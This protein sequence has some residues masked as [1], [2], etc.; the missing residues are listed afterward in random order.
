MVTKVA[1]YACVSSEQQLE[2]FSIEA[3]LRVMRDYAQAQGWLIV[4]EY[5]DEGYSAGTGQRP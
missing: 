5:V 1:L 4:R 2:G 3:Q